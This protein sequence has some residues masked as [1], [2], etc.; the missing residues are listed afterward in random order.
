MSPALVKSLLLRTRNGLPSR[1]TPP[2]SSNRPALT[3]GVGTPDGRWTRP[4]PT[5]SVSRR[6]QFGSEESWR[7][8]WVSRRTRLGSHREPQHPPV[9]PP[10]HTPVSDPGPRNLGPKT[11]VF[12]N[13]NPSEVTGKEVS[14]T[15]SLHRGRGD[16]LRRV[17]TGV[18][19]N[20]R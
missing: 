14:P 18:L 15:R 13:P 7:N 3:K 2:W 20:R 19:T 6:V 17:T 1:K 8:L 16:G 11:G 4:H 9:I 5:S 12:V 10:V